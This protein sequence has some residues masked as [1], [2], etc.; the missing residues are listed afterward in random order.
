MTLKRTG[1]LLTPDIT[2]VLLRPFYPQSDERVRKILKRVV[3]IPEQQVQTLL[4]DVRKDFCSRHHRLEAYLMTRYLHVR[5]HLPKSAGTLTDNRKLLIGAYFTQEYSFEAAALFNP[6]IV[7]HPDQSGLVSGTKRFI[8]SMRSTGEGHISSICF[9]SGTINAKNQI[10]MDPDHKF[11]VVGELVPDAYYDRH[12]FTWKLKE[13]GIT[14]SAID[15]VFQGL[16]EKFTIHELDARLEIVSEHHKTFEDHEHVFDRTCDHIMSLA[17]SNYEVFFRADRPLSERVLFPT[18]PNERNGMEDAR[19]VQFTELDTVRYYATYTAYNGLTTVPQ[20]IETEDFLRF[21]ISTLN[22]T[23]ILNKGMALFPRKIGGKYAMLSRQDNENIY[24]ML[25]DHPHF[26]M[27]KELLISPKEPWEFVQMGN[28]GSPI[29]TDRGWLV[30]SHGVGPMR[31]YSIS[32]FLLDLDDPRKIIGRL[33]EP[34][35]K[36]EGDERNGYVPN[37][38]YS[39]GSVV[40]GDSLIL[41][42]AV[43]DYATSFAVG[44][45]SEILHAMV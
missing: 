33:K 26:W 1:I 22:G 13:I 12:L 19:F 37:V 43:S 4:G 17:Q 11:A 23:E 21:N 25:S 42:Y 20:M 30:L 31:Q 44:S 24:L 7:W 45:V 5:K 6:S 35:L 32:A 28:C 18:T 16:G 15:E 34:L 39:C 29:E 41:P 9:Q 27:S 38:V 10:R 36:A 40:H 14:S 2:R 8:L 3:A